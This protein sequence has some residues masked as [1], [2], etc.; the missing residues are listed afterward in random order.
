MSENTV[1]TADIRLVPIE[2]KHTPFLRELYFTTRYDIDRAPI[3]DDQRHQLKQM[4]F[5]AQHR[6]YQQHYASA[7]FDL[8]C[9]DNKPIGRIYVDVRQEEVRL[10]D[11]SLLPEYRNQGIGRQ[12]L[13]DC[14]HT[15]Q[16]AGL[17]LRLRVEPDN[18]A[19]RLYRRLGFQVIAD[20]Q[21]NLHMEWTPDSKPTEQ[22]DG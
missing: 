21:T 7:S 20:E 3:S 11:I 5:D 22:A 9:R 10:I 19:L 6:Y 1:S 18:P 12:L 15:A 4:Q 8:I 2:P 14:Q 13:I 17:P 16:K